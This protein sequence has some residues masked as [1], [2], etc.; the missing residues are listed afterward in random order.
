MD[1][2]AQPK[3]VINAAKTFYR[4]SF[5]VRRSQRFNKHSRTFAVHHHFDA[6]LRRAILKH[7]KFTSLSRR[8]PGTSGPKILGAAT[9]H[10]RKYLAKYQH[11]DEAE[12][13]KSE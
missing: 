3:H 12:G 13:E 9:D 6:F 11:D 7:H 1:V 10:L 4:L 8:A 5:F 2:N